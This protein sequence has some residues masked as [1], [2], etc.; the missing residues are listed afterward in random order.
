MHRSRVAVLVF[1][2]AI[3]VGGYA[4]TAL[5][6]PDTSSTSTPTTAASTPRP[7][8]VENHTTTAGGTVTLTIAGVGTVTLTVDPT[9]AAISDVV[10]T[11]ID[12]VTTGAPVTTPEGVKIQVTAADGTMQVLEIKARHEDGGLEVESELGVE[13]EAE[14]HDVGD[15]HGDGANRGPGNQNAQNND[16]SGPGRRGR[17]DGADNAT[18]PTTGSP[19]VFSPSGSGSDD[20]GGDS[21]SDNRSG[22][23]GGGQSGHN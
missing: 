16:N 7:T 10:V 15:D 19:Q 1:G 21:G 14:N 22:G 17:D 12:G 4:T 6:S 13:N 2:A 20:H 11:P 23:S 5:A 18:S 3:A 9:T 8:E